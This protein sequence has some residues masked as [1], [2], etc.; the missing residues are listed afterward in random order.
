MEKCK[1]IIMLRSGEREECMSEY[2]KNISRHLNPDVRKNLKN[3]FK[4]INCDI[5]FTLTQILLFVLKCAPHL[6]TQFYCSCIIKMHS[7]SAFACQPDDVYL[8]FSLFMNDC[9]TDLRLCWAG[10]IAGALSFDWQYMMMR[11][12]P[13]EIT[14]TK[15]HFDY[16]AENN[17]DIIFVVCSGKFKF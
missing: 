7:C 6:M 17:H 12:M 14:H 3:I 16:S 1:L 13:F 15:C 4:V 9:E 8:K 11:R 10:I 5:N 2:M